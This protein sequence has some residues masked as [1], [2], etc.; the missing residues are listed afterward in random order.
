MQRGS[1]EGRESGVR[2]GELRTRLPLRHAIINAALSSTEDI[3]LS[4]L[5]EKPSP[6]HDDFIE[7]GID[8]APAQ[9][10][11]VAHKDASYYNPIDSEEHQDSIT[12]RVVNSHPN[13]PSI[14]PGGTTFMDQFFN[15]KCAGH[16]Q[17]N[18]YYPFASGTEWQLASWLLRSH[19]S[20]DSIDNFLSLRLIKQLPLSFRTAKELRLHAEMLPSGP[21]WKSHVLRTQ[22]AT[23]RKVMIIYHD[24][25]ECLQALLSHPLFA[26]HISFVP[27]KVWSSSARMV[28][29]YDEWMSGDH[30]WSLQKLVYSNPKKDQLPNGAT[31]LGV[32]LSSDKT[33]I[34]VMTGNRMAHPLL[35]SLANIDADIHSKGSLH[36]HVLLALLPVPSF[37]HKQMHVC[38]LLSDRLFHECLDL[39]LKPLKIAATVRIMMSDPVE[40]LVTCTS[41][42]AS[43][44]LTVIYKQFSDSFR[45]PPRTAT[46]TLDEIEQACS[47]ANLDDFK[48]FL[49]VIKRFRLNGVDKS[50]FRDWLLSEPLI[51]ITP[52]TL[53]V[54]HRLF[55]DH[56]LQWSVGYRSFEEGVSKLE[57]VMGRDHRAAQRY[58]V[59]VIAGAV[60]PKF[61]AAISALLDF[62]YLAQMPCFDKDALT[63]V[64]AVLERFH[65]HKSAIISTGG[66]QGSKGPLKHWEI[67]KLELLQ[68]VVPSIRASGAIM[69]WTAD[70]TEHA[71]VTKIKQPTRSG[72]NQDYYTQI[73]W[74]LNRSEKCFRFDITMHLASVEHKGSDDKDQADEHEPNLE[75]LCI[76]H[77][78]S[79]TRQTA[80]YFEMAEELA[81]S[82][83][84]NTALP[85]RIFASSTTAFR[86]A[87]KPSL[88]ASID[89]A[90]EMD[91]Q[92]V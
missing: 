69:Q 36:A 24:P 9:G 25:V 87:L 62:R 74:H 84:P 92:F 38:S 70:V 41:P 49:K 58:I 42:K 90:A 86:L 35:L 13:T 66:R 46:M 4:R 61:L 12:S 85:H 2:L 56:N 91:V 65:T 19:L 88:R 80:N 75:A 31:L 47:M 50:F 79:P 10:N 11:F 82:T 64:E 73:A 3:A 43:P 78:Y 28:R 81:S 76:K 53:H 14:Y 39:V 55:W 45:H 72:N 48:D 54:F 67:P 23:K 57:Q 29:I 21:H 27:Q 7:D 68:H 1:W 63:K 32:V 34:S 60:P 17:D 20:M 44:V 15:D 22:V 8:E 5:W 51:F 77:Y 37:I 52:E 83:V 26:S 6:D 71:H 59:G 30:A 40:C 33:N 16:H 89:E 18:L